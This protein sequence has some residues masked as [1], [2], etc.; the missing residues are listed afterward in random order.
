MDSGP[1][2]WSSAGVSVEVAREARDTLGYITC[3]ALQIL[4]LNPMGT[5]DKRCQSISQLR[6]HS[7]LMVGSE[8]KRNL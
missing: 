1:Y 3:V 6:G 8:S 5:G 7:P 4:G 2:S